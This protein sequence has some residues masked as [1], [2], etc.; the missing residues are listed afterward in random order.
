MCSAEGVKEARAALRGKLFGL[1]SGVDPTA[2]VDLTK[3]GGFYFEG[4][5]RNFSEWSKTMVKEFGAKVKP[6]LRKVWGKIN[7][8]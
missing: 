1:H 4:G 3:I 5:I 2:V 8:E 6:Y 7:K